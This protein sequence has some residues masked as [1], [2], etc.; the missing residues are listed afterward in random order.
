MESHNDK[1]TAVHSKFTDIRDNTLYA[2]LKPGEYLIAAKVAW[3]EWQLKPKFT[4]TSYGP[5]PV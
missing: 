5:S 2:K 1:L 3:E 4:V